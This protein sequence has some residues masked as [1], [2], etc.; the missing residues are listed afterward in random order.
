VPGRGVVRR[1]KRKRDPDKVISMMERRA[2]DY[3]ETELKINIAS[4]GN[5]VAVSRILRAL[6]EFKRDEAPAQST[7]GRSA[8]QRQFR[9]D[10]G[11]AD[12]RVSPGSQPDDGGNPEA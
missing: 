10:A 9:F 3:L 2:L 11:V 12:Q 7:D 1:T 8:L 6:K 5:D 4:P